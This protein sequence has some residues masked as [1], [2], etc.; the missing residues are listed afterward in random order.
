M[1]GSFPLTYCFFQLTLTVWTLLGA[2]GLCAILI[3]VKAITL[4]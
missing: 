3:I 4:T 1:N 2:P